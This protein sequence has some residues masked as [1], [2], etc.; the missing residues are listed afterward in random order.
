MG[1]TRRTAGIQHGVDTVQYPETYSNRPIPDGIST[2]PGHPLATVIKLFSAL[3]IVLVLLACLIL[4]VARQ[5][6]AMLASFEK[7]LSLF[8]G[9]EIIEIHDA[10]M[11]VQNYLSDLDTTLSVD[12]DMTEDFSLSVHVDKESVINA[13]TTV[14]CHVIYYR[15]LLHG[16]DSENAL[17][18]LIAHELAHIK[19]RGQIAPLGQ[20]LAI[21]TG[22]EL[23]LGTADAGNLGKV[24]F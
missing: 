1:R 21:Q 13:L 10:R 4:I 12:M 18:M 19:R 14:G 17:A 2:S 24:G 7:E 5:Q 23:V 22:M 20:G 9:M 8:S 6:L 15:G 3:L 16:L 11:Q